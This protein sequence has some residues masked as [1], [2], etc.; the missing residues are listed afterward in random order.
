MVP[1]SIAGLFDVGFCGGFSV[2]GV[3]AGFTLGTGVG[4]AEG[5]LVEMPFEGVATLVATTVLEVVDVVVTPVTSLYV[6][7]Q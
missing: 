4:M 5:I 2:I 7:P 3:A 6:E 1:A